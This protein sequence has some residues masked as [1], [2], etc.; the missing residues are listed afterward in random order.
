MIGLMPCPKCAFDAPIDKSQKDDSRNG[1]NFKFG[2]ISTMNLMCTQIREK[3]STA[4]EPNLRHVI[5][6]N[7]AVILFNFCEHIII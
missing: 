7:Y 3:N 2:P 6:C 4:Q 1:L 5:T